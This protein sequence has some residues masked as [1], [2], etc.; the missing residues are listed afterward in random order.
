MRIAYID[1]HPVPGH[2]P[3]A[4][5]ILQT[6]N[7]LAQIGVKLQLVTPTAELSADS[8]LGQA[9][10][11]NLVFEPLHKIRHW[12]Q[13][14]RSNQGFYRQALAWLRANPVDA[15][16]VRNLKLADILLNSPGLP[17]V[18]F[19]T[20]ELFA[21]TYRED[22]P[23]PNWSQRRKL[24]VL[25]A[26]E[27]RVYA[28]CRGLLALT[29]LLL[30]DIQSEYQI[31]TPGLVVADGVDLQLAAQALAS[32]SPASQIE[33]PARL[34][35]LGSLHPWKGVETLIR[36]MPSIAKAELWI[37]GGGEERIAQ[38]R[39]L[40]ASLNLATDRVQFLGSIAPIKRFELIGQADICLLPLTQTS[41]G[42]RYTSPLKLFEYMAMHK[43][44]VIA[45]LPSIREVLVD[46]QTAL[47]AECESPV[48][49]AEKINQLLAE[50]LL[51]QRLAQ[52]AGELAQAY[53]W[54]ARAEKI[55]HFIA[56]QLDVV[57]Q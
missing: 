31:R 41:I 38:L 25:A 48:S 34:L 40:A 26:R 22:H 32:Q 53:S 42:S 9:A 12:W 10:A 46:G 21:Q 16:L 35:Y 20:H 37:A 14:K 43:A 15:V 51:M 18:F 52:Q 57:C 50:P 7:G 54:S 45:D 11:A 30:T 39:Q 27:A 6:A 29:Q 36:A 1:P 56:Q 28:R 8:V 33:R 13:P 2:Q 5:Q 23:R 44:I 17:P 24:S 3:E 19:E 47:L 4:L 55:R 49:F